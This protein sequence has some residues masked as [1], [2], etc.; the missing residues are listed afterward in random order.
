M[1]LLSSFLNTV[2]FNISIVITYIAG[3]SN[4]VADLLG[5]GGAHLVSIEVHLDY[6]LLNHGD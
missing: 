5:H 3:T 1:F 6:P 4:T 2:I